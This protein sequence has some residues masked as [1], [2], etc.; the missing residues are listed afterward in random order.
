M[1]II[2]V[3]G[4]AT[5]IVVTTGTF[6]FSINFSFSPA[7]LTSTPPLRIR[8]FLCR[9]KHFISFLYLSDMYPVKSAYIHGYPHGERVLCLDRSLEYQSVPA[10][11][12][13]LGDIKMPSNNNLSEVFPVPSQPYL[14]NAFSSQPNTSTS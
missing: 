6:S 4:V 11:F 1:D 9:L 13:G 5:I 10:W 7:W 2:R 12:P 3:K 14:G 8:E